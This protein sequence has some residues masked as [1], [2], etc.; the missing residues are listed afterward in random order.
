MRHGFHVCYVPNIASMLSLPSLSSSGDE[1]GLVD[2]DQ[3]EIFVPASEEL[4]LYKI[5]FSSVSTRRGFEAFELVDT[6]FNKGY[7]HIVLLL[8]Q[9]MGV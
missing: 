7:T 8:L 3:N 9:H 5:T 6:Q 2:G 1:G 4:E